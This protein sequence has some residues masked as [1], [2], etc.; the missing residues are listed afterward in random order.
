[1][2]TCNQP[3]STPPSRPRPQLKNLLVENQGQQPHARYQ[4]SNLSINVLDWMVNMDICWHYRAHIQLWTHLP[5]PPR[6]RLKTLLVET[7][8]VATCGISQTYQLNLLDWM[9][10]LWIWLEL[11]CPH[12]ALELNSQAVPDLGWKS[13]LYKQGQYPR[14]NDGSQTCQLHVRICEVECNYLR[15][16]KIWDELFSWDTSTL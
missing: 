15:A 6:P 12:S 7:R 13:S 5:S 10:K 4:L 3:W 14:A 1:V 9:V 2:P 11:S 8:S 16:W